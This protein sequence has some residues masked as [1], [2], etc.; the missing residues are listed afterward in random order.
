MSVDGVRD[1]EKVF[2]LKVNYI[3]NR[4]RGQ[5]S[6]LDIKTFFSLVPPTTRENCILTEILVNIT[7]AGYKNRTNRLI[8]D[9]T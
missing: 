1:F 2:V 7:V 6:N 8:V 5:M 4:L 9:N 3:T